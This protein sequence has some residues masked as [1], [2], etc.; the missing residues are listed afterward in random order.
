MRRSLAVLLS[1]SLAL[2]G[3]SAV[4]IAAAGGGQVDEVKSEV[5]IRKAF[6]PFHGRV[7][8]GAGDCVE[9]RR[10]KLFKQR[11]NRGP[12]LLGYDRTD[13]EGRWQVLLDPLKS[14]SYFAVVKRVERGAAGTIYDC[15]RDRS[16]TLTVD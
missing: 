1:L 13:G 3:G 6:P 11:R 10:V 5:K 7:L 8:A 14:G 15:L 12:K 9:A 4:A 16:R 2:A